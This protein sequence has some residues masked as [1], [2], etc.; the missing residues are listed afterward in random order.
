MDF[1]DY[2]SF[3]RK[4]SRRSSDHI[5]GFEAYMNS[6]CSWYRYYWYSFALLARNVYAYEGINEIIQVGYGSEWNNE[7]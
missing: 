7:K 2:C 5:A 1:E 4:N 6:S 3:R